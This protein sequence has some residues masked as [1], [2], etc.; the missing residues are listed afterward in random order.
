MF[1]YPFYFDANEIASE[2]NFDAHEIADETIHTISRVSTSSNPS[3][4]AHESTDTTI[5]KLSL[6]THRPTSS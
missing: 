5:F 1:D 3:T 2:T 6:G 4:N